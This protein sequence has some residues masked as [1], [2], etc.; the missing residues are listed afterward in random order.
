MS[1]HKY[2]IML[3]LRNPKQDGFRFYTEHKGGESTSHQLFK[4]VDEVHKKIT[5]LKAGNKLIGVQ[6]I[7]IVEVL[8]H[9]QLQE[10]TNI[11]IDKIDN[12]SWS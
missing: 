3:E 7:I 5:E 12:D 2:S 9:Y 11:K 10:T 8:E 1:D 6:R 4:S